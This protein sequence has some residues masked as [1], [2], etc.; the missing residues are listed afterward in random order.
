[1]ITVITLIILRKYNLTNFNVNLITYCTLH[2]YGW[3]GVKIKRKKFR[4]FHIC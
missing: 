4:T 1:M 2:V 3:A